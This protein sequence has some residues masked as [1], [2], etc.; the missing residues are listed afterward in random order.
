MKKT[1]LAL[2]AVLCLSAYAQP[3]LTVGDGST[4]TLQNIGDVD[5][6]KASS[7]STLVNPSA[8]QNGND[9][10]N[11]VDTRTQINPNI[12]PN[13][14]SQATGA[15]LGNESKAAASNGDQSLDASTRS[16]ASNGDQ[17]L[18]GTNKQGQGQGQQ[19]GQGQTSETNGTVK[20]TVKSETNGT[21]NGGNQR[22]QANGNGASAGAGAGAGAGSNNRTANNVDASNRSKTTYTAWAPMTHGAGA[23]ALPTALQAPVIRGCGPRFHMYKVAVHGYFVGP[24]GGV[25][26][27]VIGYKDEIGPWLDENGNKAPPSQL[28]TY[29]PIYEIDDMGFKRIVGQRRWGMELMGNAAVLSVSSAASLGLGLFDGGKGAQAGAAGSGGMQAQS[30]ML[31]AFDCAEE[32]YIEVPK[33]DAPPAVTVVPTC[34]PAP[35]AVKRRHTPAPMVC[36]APKADRS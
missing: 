6:S 28:F 36:P 8:N 20:G 18:T 24:F 14:T 7:A 15:I 27:K 31:N 23:A 11:N 35:K 17:S 4:G 13:T 1:L 34:V 12:N 16:N 9:L 26:E 25:T 21:V 30:Q 10:G 19:M 33:P 5:A 2:S 3:A 32:R 29:E 22:T